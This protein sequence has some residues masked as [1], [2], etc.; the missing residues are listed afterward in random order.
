MTTRELGK[1]RSINSKGFGFIRTPDR[2]DY[3]F[4]YSALENSSLDEL[5]E[6]ETVSFEIAASDRGPRA[7]AVRVEQAA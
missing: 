7:C 2:T 4:H 6:G 5:Q 3:F 1:V